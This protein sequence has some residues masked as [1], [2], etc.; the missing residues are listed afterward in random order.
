MKTESDCSIRAPY[1][2]PFYSNMVEVHL[3]IG[4]PTG[5]FLE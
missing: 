1:R 4:R 3:L 2:V 5:S